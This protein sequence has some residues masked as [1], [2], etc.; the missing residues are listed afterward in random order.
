MWKR[1]EQ[2][3]TKI[4]SISLMKIQVLY[5]AA[6]ATG[7]KANHSQGVASL[8][9]SLDNFLLL[10]NTSAFR[11]LSTPGDPH[12]FGQPTSSAPLVDTPWFAA[13]PHEGWHS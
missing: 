1:K 5:Q 13:G 6:Q 2:E 7:G 12:S 8:L 10:S 11:P 3:K 4:F 9:T